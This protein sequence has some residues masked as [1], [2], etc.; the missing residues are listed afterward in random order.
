[1]GAERI[2]EPESLSPVHRVPDGHMLPVRGCGC[3]VDYMQ[4]VSSGQSSMNYS[5][6]LLEALG[7][8]ECPECFHLLK[9]HT[10]KYGCDV[11]RGDRPG[12][13][14]TIAEARGPCSCQPDR[15]EYPGIYLAITTMRKA[16]KEN[17]VVAAGQKQSS[18]DD[19]G[20]KRQAAEPE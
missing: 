15:N 12:N 14:W 13:E 6:Q 18:E 16:A 5:P 1:M 7:N 11:E 19:Q 3:A 8:I 10:D 2:Q 17:L 20:A 4:Q 9:H